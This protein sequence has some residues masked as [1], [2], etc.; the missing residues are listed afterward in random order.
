MK[1]FPLLSA[2]GFLA[3]SSVT[4]SAAPL[5]LEKTYGDIFGGGGNETLRIVNTGTPNLNQRVRAGGFRVTDA[6]NKIDLIA[7]CVDIAHSLTLKGLYEITSAPFSNTF[8][9]SDTQKGNIQSLFNTAYRDLDLTNDGQSAGFQLALWEI[10]YEATGTLDVE[11]GTF[12]TVASMDAVAAANGFLDNLGG[13]ISKS[14]KID[15]YE[16]LGYRNGTRY[17][18]NLVSA[19]P[20]PLPAAGLLLGCGLAGLYFSG[21]RQKK[22]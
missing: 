20:V 10:A 5:K 13:P 22:S 9:F 18:Q 12:S 3:I 14:Y 19:T 2:C 15:Y 8:S 1:L 21:R 17:S 4:A 6:T 7:W 11:T 16:S